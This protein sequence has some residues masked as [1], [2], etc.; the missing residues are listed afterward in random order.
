MAFARLGTV[1]LMTYAL[2]T[3]TNVARR[4]VQVT[5]TQAVTSVATTIIFFQVA[6]TLPMALVIIRPMAPVIIATELPERAPREVKPRSVAAGAKCAFG[7][8]ISENDPA[9]AKQ[10]GAGIPPFPSPKAR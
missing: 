10:R 6:L 9:S 3:R 2:G 1:G 7:A 8:G 4:V 5:Q